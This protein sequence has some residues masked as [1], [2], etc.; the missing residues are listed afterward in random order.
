MRRILLP[1]CLAIIAACADTGTTSTAESADT[2]AWSP[3]TTNSDGLKIETNVIILLRES[4]MLEYMPITMWVDIA[5][6]GWIEFL[7]D[8]RQHYL[9]GAPQPKSRY[10][11]QLN[12]RNT[13][14]NIR[15]ADIAAMF[16]TTTTDAKYTVD[17]PEN[18]GKIADQ[19]FHVI[20]K[21]STASH[22]EVASWN[23][24]LLAL[25]EDFERGMRPGEPNP[26]RKEYLMRTG[27]GK[28]VNTLF[29]D[30]RFVR[31]LVLRTYVPLGSK[32]Y[33]LPALGEGLSWGVHL[34]APW[35]PL[36]A[37]APDA[38]ERP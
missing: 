29:L 17:C 35:S 18:P 22:G 28:Y 19:E 24:G 7:G 14:L 34:D 33:E 38:V 5:N 30:H 10:Q 27:C 37:M 21:E 26:G 15:L 23:R 20:F 12:G 3:V 6:A 2:T 8:F 31:A 16:I 4:G 25:V 11:M 36:T 13:H 32:P 9:T 1:I